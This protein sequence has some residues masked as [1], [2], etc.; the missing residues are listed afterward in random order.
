MTA[1]TLSTVA[2]ADMEVPSIAVACPTMRRC[3]SGPASR[4][5]SGTGIDRC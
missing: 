1:K 2:Q 4:G 3:Q 5:P